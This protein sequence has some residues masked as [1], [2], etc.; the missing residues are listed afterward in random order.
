MFPCPGVLQREFIPALLVVCVVIALIGVVGF[1]GYGVA[2]NSVISVVAIVEGAEFIIPGKGTVHA[3][4]INTAIVKETQER[5]LHAAARVVDGHI[6]TGCFYN[7]CVDAQ[8]FF[9][10]LKPE[11]GFLVAGFAALCA[12]CGNKTY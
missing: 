5:V 11:V 3:A 9:H 6:Y 1:H 2:V 4:D 7:I 12:C 8:S 10:Q